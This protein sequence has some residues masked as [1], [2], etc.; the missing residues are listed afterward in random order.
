[1]DV[2][3]V[4]PT[5]RRPHVLIRCLMAIDQQDYPSSR[6]E[7]VVV[8]DRADSETE[9]TVLFMQANTG[10]KVRY[11]P[12]SQ[13]RGPAAARN[14]GWRSAQAN[15]VAFIDDDCIPQNNWLSRGLAA[16]G[17]DSDALA[18]AGKII[19]PIAMRPTDYE[20]DQAGL[21]STEF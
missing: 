6:Y 15:V 20:R 13:S 11:L 2:T 1:M 18:V 10:M 9:A 17:C 3:V 5:F 14:L 7:V 16:L 12:M 21:E 8:S 4:I 19:V